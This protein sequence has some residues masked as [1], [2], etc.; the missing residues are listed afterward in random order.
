MP[1]LNYYVKWRTR[2]VHPLILVTISVAVI[3]VLHN[4]TFWTI[5]DDVFAGAKIRGVIFALALLLLC[6]GLVSIFAMKRILQPFI[7]FLFILS[8]VTSYYMDQLGVIIDREMIQNVVTTTLMEGK[9]LVT[10][11]FLIWVGASGIVPA[12]IVF[13]VKVDHPKFFHSVLQNMLFLVF[14]VLGT[15]ILVATDIKGNSSVLRLRIDLKSSFQ[16]LAP[17]T[18]SFLY[19]AMITRSATLEFKEIGT[20]ATLNSNFRNQ[21]KPNLI[22]VVIGETARSQ[23]FSLGSYNRSTNPKLKNEDIAYYDNVSSCGTSTAVS[24]PCMFSN[25]ERANYSYEKGTSQENVLDIIQRAGYQVEWIDN[26]T[27]DKG[28]AARAKYTQVTYAKNIKFCGEGECLDGILVDEVA[29][30]LPEIQKNTVLVLH[31]IG[32]HG[33][34]YYLRYPRALEK[35][36]PACRTSNFFECTKEE[37]VNAYDNSIAYTDKVNAD[38]IALLKKQSS[39]T[40]S[41]IYVSDHG[42]SLGENGL[43]LH[44]APY[45]M[46]PR[47]QT[48]VPMIVWL[49]DAYKNLTSITSECLRTVSTQK[50]SHANFFHSLLGMTGVETVEYKP[51]LDIFNRCGNNADVKKD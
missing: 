14:C 41:M 20:D 9:H 12:I 5:W 47:E 37:I 30:R 2:S 22:V 26:N 21:G 25:F 11:S 45:F 8:S 33:P 43:F 36:K 50:Y 49:S 10:K 34:S 48:K 24:L 40:T 13:Y 3:F 4:T 15:V 23:S 18:E 27:G 6:C 29:K 28:L 44:G 35:F 51:I 17:I 19:L 46:A 1:P 31:Q 32:S 7:A 38:L 16:P 42:E 39:V